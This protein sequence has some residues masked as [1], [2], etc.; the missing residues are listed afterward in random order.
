MASVI[1]NRS[2][3]S[4]TRRISS[5]NL[6][7][8]LARSSSEKALSSLVR[9]SFA[10][11]RHRLRNTSIKNLPPYEYVPEFAGRMVGPQRTSTA[12]VP[13]VFFTPA[14]AIDD[15]PVRLHDIYSPFSWPYAYQDSRVVRKDPDLQ[16]SRAVEPFYTNRI[17]SYPNSEARSKRYYAGDV[18]YYFDDAD[19]ATDA[20]LRWSLGVESRESPSYHSYYANTG[21]LRRLGAYQPSL[22]Q[23]YLR[24]PWR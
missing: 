4:S 20:Y 5:L 9:K 8:P 17:R 2:V 10:P 12:Y 6:A 3:R 18:D 16:G 15:D 14:H 13:N 24:S 11:V 1:E 7:P 19:R 23:R 22:L 21:L